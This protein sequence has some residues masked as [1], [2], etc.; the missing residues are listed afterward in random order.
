MVSAVGADP[1]NCGVTG[2]GPLTGTIKGVLIYASIDSIDGKGD[3]TNGNV[4]A[5]S[6]PCYLRTDAQGG[7]DYRT[8]IG[9]MAFD[10]ADIAGLSA[11]GAL[12]E[13]IMHEM[14][15]VIGFGSFWGPNDKNLLVNPGTPAVAYTGPGGI[16]GCQSIGGTITCA[17]TVPVEGDQ[18]GDGTK[19]S[20]WREATFGN[21]LMTGFIS[22]GANPLSAMSIR[23]LEDLGYTVNTAAADSYTIPGGHL[24]AA[25]SVTSS[26]GLVGKGW[27]RR[28]KM[29]IRKLPVLGLAGIQN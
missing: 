26:A 24:L 4:I 18:G 28:R 2:Q 10:T 8:V 9:V 23:S 7:L 19:D 13:V 22:N 27:E 25:G 16:T 21:E 3:P 29:K 20:H 15:H 17:S 1:S 5:N 6:G 14:M 11:G 12:K